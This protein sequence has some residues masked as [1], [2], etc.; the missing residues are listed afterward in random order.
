MITINIILEKYIKLNKELIENEKSKI[1]LCAAETYISDFCKQPLISEFEGK[2]SF[3]DKNGKHIFI[4]GEYVSRL[5]ELLSEECKILFN[6]NY[7]NADTLTGINCFSVCAMSLLSRNEWVLVTTPDQ[8]GHASIPIILDSL[9]V[10]YDTI[11]FDYDKYQIDY[12]NLNK[13][14]DTGKYKFIIFCQSD[15]INPPDINR[16]NTRD[17]MGIIYDGTQTLGLIAGKVIANPLDF[18]KVILIGGTHKTL[19][20]PSCGL[21]MTNNT[22][23]SDKLKHNITPKYLRNTQPNH[24]AALLLGLIEQ[25]KFGI[26]YQTKTVQLANSLGKALEDYNFRLAKIDANTYTYTHQLFVLMSADDAE[27]YYLNAQKFNISLNKKHKKLFNNDGIRLGLQQVSRYAWNNAEIE[28]LAK[29]LYLVQKADT[30]QKEIL[31]LRN[32]LIEKKIP[33][34]EYECISIK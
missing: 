8:G 22:S 24:I 23:F 20:V 9:G 26:A 17:D 5:N 19:P 16:I 12:L 3:T 15:V 13:L 33:Q 1:P 32:S 34:F 31:K 4:G 25:E 6:A 2:Y 21:I 18:D 28:Q 11:P 7:T 14:C 30:E 29:L 10:N 27:K